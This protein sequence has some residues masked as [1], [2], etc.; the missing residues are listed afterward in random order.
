MRIGG[1][2]AAGI[3][4]AGFEDIV[5]GFGEGAEVESREDLRRRWARTW[6][7]RLSVRIMSMFLPN[8][9]A[10]SN[11]QRIE[12]RRGCWAPDPT[13]RASMSVSGACSVDFGRFEGDHPRQC[14]LTRAGWYSYQA[15]LAA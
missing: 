13:P 3:F 15:W 10:R 12:W 11:A 1:G 9:K 4:A 7:E 6:N 8:R 5:G 14:F 2:G